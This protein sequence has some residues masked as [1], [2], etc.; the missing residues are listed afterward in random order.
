VGEA[1]DHRAVLV[2]VAGGE[3][4][5]LAGR[6]VTVVREQAPRLR[7]PEPLGDPGALDRLL[8]RPPAPRRE[9]PVGVEAL[10]HRFSEEGHVRKRRGAERERVHRRNYAAKGSDPS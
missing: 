6:G 4:R 5:H 9:R 10:L 1:G 7:Q 8:R 2:A 3:Q